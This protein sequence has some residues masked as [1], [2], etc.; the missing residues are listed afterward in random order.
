[1]R[2]IFFLSAVFASLLIVA[3][4]SNNDAKK[5]GAFNPASLLDDTTNKDNFTSIKWLDS[6]VDFGVATYGDKAKVLFHFL[7]TGTKPLYIINAR[8]GCG[9][10]VAD[11]T[12][13]AVMPG[14]QGV[15]TAVY[16]T[17]H[18]HSGEVVHKA[19]YITCNALPRT[20]QTLEFTGMVKDSTSK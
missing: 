4:N 8:P 17:R 1:M 10:T 20:Q 6:I 9:C 7:N 13:G 12:K 16:D 2:K 11:F 18:G 5:N 15:V 19:I 3:C 14:K